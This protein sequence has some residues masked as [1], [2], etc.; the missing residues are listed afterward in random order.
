MPKSLR[1]RAGETR[2]SR[3]GTEIAGGDGPVHPSRNAKTPEGHVRAAG[4]PD[5]GY[6]QAGLPDRGYRQ[7]G[8]PVAATGKIAV[9]VLSRMPY[10]RTGK[11]KGR[12][13]RHMVHQ[14]GIC[15]KRHIDA[16]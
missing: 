12:R 1:R 14:A 3:P 5:R 10:G 9:R 11:R 8:L 7:A 16:L 15:L 6:R 2:D 4:L 13:L